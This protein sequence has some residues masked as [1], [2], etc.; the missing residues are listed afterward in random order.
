M[1][2]RPHIKQFFMV[3]LPEFTQLMEI[4]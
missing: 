2:F 4:K 1:P 3:E